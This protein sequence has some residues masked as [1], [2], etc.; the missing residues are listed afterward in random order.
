[1]AIFLLLAFSIA[2]GSALIKNNKASCNCFGSGKEALSQYELVRNAGLI[3]CAVS[4]LLLLVVSPEGGYG[5][6]DGIELI[7]LAMVAAVFS[8][9]WINMRY[10]VEFFLTSG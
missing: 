10:I 4:G 1:M 8:L 5:T 6:L 7:S 9:I 3:L 2:I